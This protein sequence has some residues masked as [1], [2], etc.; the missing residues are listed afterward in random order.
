MR[1]VLLLTVLWATASPLAAQASRYDL[2]IREHIF[3]NGLR[4][5]VLERPGDHRVAAKIFTEMG[6]LNE[7]PGELGTAHFL[8]HLM[9]KGTP[10]LGTTD[11]EAERPLHDRI[12]A[13]EKEF[14]A[15]R[16]RARQELRERGVFHD[17]RRAE[18]TPRMDS[19]RAEIARLD[20]EVAPL[21]ENGA[22]MKWYQAFG[23]TGLTATTE[24]EYMKFDI[25]LPAD[26]VAL[27]LRVE[28]DRMRNT[29]FREFDQERMILVEQ[30]YGD[31]NRNVTP[32]YEAMN[33]LVQTVHPVFWPEG[34]LTDFPQYTRAYHRDLYENYFIP[35]NTT[36]VLIGGVSL[37]A[38]IP[39]VD[40]YFGWMEREPEPTRTTAIEPVPQAEKRLIWRS[41]TLEPR[42][43]ARYLIPG[44]GHPDRP[45]FD[46]LAEVAGAELREAMRTAGINGQVNVNTQVVHTSRF[47]VPAT[48]NVELVVPD[49][50][51]LDAAERVLFA[52]LDGLGTDPASDDRL[53][54]AK[55][56]L[57]AEWYRLAL[58]P[59]RLGF[60]IGHFQTMDSW[61]A[62]EPY[63][64]ARETTTPADLQRLARRY[65]VPENRSVGV[66]RPAEASATR[67]E[68]N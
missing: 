16:N 17:G 36:I 35:N 14:V 12:M 8:E 67:T 58:D 6:P 47:G 45:H 11:W 7:T 19:L 54:L 63:L 68:A 18:S 60:E 22:M 40:R 64:E 9:F 29:V 33:A 49:A 13:L 32:Y 65:F 31:L 46:V 44:V 2:P 28:A 20:L 43:E 42:V 15:E 3:P 56:R 10:T 57:R 1:L 66:V 5:L 25:N 48:L 39:L 59:D 55:K 24:Q 23:G 30:R 62:L 61:R 27:F 52:T 26:R 21:R 51:R 34:Y 50:A 37:E 41:T 38:M 53:Q 4:L